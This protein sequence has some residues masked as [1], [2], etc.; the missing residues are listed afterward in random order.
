[1]ATGSLGKNETL[2]ALLNRFA[3][4]SACRAA[5]CSA[6][7]RQQYRQRRRAPAHTAFAAGSTTGVQ[8]P[9]IG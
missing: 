6:S 7:T 4:T 5:K 2:Q 9:S 1:M 8:S 3:S